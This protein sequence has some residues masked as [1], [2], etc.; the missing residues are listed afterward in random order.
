MFNQDQQPRETRPSSWKRLCKFAVDF[1]DGETP[2][3]KL[4]RVFFK[5]EAADLSGGWVPFI[6]LAGFLAYGVWWITATVKDKTIKDK[7]D[8]TA[9]LRLENSDL[10]RDR[11][12]FEL[13]L[14]ILEKGANLPVQ[15]NSPLD[16]RLDLL[17]ETLVKALPP[18]PQ[19]ELLFNAAIAKNNTV[20]Q[21][22]KSRTFRIG[23]LN[24]SEIT[25]ENLTVRFSGQLK[26]TNVTTK[27]WIA[28]GESGSFENQELKP[29]GFPVWTTKFRDS[30]AG[31]ETWQT[32]PITVSTNWS[33]PYFGSTI[34]IHSDRSK[35]HAFNVVFV[36]GP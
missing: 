34:F 12:K 20:I 16:K 7:T 28:V 10:K 22:D 9:S 29:S 6:V 35:A 4:L 24:L 5:E 26:E 23:V 15:T 2:R 36:F 14:T 8:E 33:Q 21:L 17:L 13:K 27:D 1:W 25:A 3:F 18:D 11:D 30:L 31:R 19:F 32:W